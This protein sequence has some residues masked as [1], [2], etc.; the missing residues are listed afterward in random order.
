MDA[1]EQLNEA[2]FPQWALDIA[3]VYMRSNSQASCDTRPRA[4]TRTLFIFEVCEMIQ[5]ATAEY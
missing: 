2:C 3:A 5:A 4:H 1:V